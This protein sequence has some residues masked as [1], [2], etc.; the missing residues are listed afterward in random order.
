MIKDIIDDLIL[1]RGKLLEMSD[2]APEKLEI[3]KDEI[4]D[5]LNIIMEVLDEV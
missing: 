1:I 4:L 5:E 2:L 3:H